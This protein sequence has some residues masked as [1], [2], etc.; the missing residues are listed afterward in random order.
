MKYRDKYIIEIYVKGVVADMPLHGPVEYLQAKI[1]LDTLVQ[2]PHRIEDLPLSIPASRSD[3]YYL[4]D[5][6]FSA[7][8]AFL[9]RGRA[10]SRK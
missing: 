2:Q 5:K 9:N 8:L 7:Y 3:F 6:Q 10:S 1:F 4:T